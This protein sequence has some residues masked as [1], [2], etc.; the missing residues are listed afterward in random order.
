[1]VPDEPAGEPGDRDDADEGKCGLSLRCSLRRRARWNRS[2][3]LAEHLQIGGGLLELRSDLVRP[4][5]WR[6]RLLVHGLVMLRQPRGSESRSLT[7]RDAAC[8]QCSGVKL[9]SRRVDAVPAPVARQF[10]A[11]CS[12]FKR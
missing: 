9:L 3:L 10:G 2:Y 4:R 5:A 7:I 1:M 6:G 11:V 8:P 12:G